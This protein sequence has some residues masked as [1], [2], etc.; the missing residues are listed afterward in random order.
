MAV[1]A[2]VIPFYPV[3]KALRAG[4]LSFSEALAGAAVAWAFWNQWRGEKRDVVQRTILDGA[5][6][7]FVLVGIAAAWI[8]PDHE[9]AWVALRRMVLAPAALY[10]LWRLLPVDERTEV[11][12]IGG[13]IVS[14]ALVSL[15]GLAD[16]A[17]GDVV[18]AGVVSRLHSIYSSPNEIALLLVRTWPLAASLA[19]AYG[20]R[21]RWLAGAATG[22]MLLALALTFSRGAW[23]LGVPVGALVLAAHY[24]RREAW[25]GGVAVVALAGM[26]FLGRGDDLSL[27]P[28]VWQAAWGMWRDHLWLG[29]GLDGF[30][31]FYP[32]YMTLSAWRE[33]L[34]YHPHN[35]ILEMGTGMGVLGLLAA[36]GIAW[37]WLRAWRRARRLGPSPIV[38]GLTAGLA[39]GMAHGMVDAGY[40]LPHLAMLTMLAL[41]ITVADVWRAHPRGV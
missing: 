39:A 16:Y 28:A 19:L 29:V 13:V 33:P 8:A 3:Q 4:W 21:R 12:A 31:W 15:I 1:L 35:V 30:Q 10:R 26:V 36:A 32:R 20:G 14:S 18:T 23:L 37:G 25:I 11:W 2:F 40:F 5:V 17:L 34:L 38:I 22:V 7:I 6:G 27:R 24:R 41:G 9:A